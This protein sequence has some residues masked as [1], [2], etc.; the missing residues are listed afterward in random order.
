MYSVLLLRTKLEPRKGSNKEKGSSSRRVTFR[1]LPFSMGPSDVY[2][3]GQNHYRDHHDNAGHWYKT[4]ANT[5]IK[6]PLMC[7]LAFFFRQLLLNVT[8]R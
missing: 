6:H 4:E 7:L 2:V 3:E 1:P 8:S 5:S